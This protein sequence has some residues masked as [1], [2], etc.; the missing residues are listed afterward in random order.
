[1]DAHHP[2]D[3]RGVEAPVI[4]AFPAPRAPAPTRPAVGARKASR[5]MGNLPEEVAGFVGRRSEISRIRKLLAEARLVTLTGPGGVGKSRLALRVAR[6]V[7]RA[8]PKGV[9]FVELS[10]LRDPSSVAETVLATLEVRDQS[11]RPAVSVLAEYL[12]DKHLLLVVDNCEHLLDRCGALLSRLLAA[13]PGLSI[14]ATSRAPLGIA[15]EHLLQ[16][17]PLSAPG[18]GTS[19]SD[20]AFAPGDGRRFESLAL[21]EQRAAAVMPDFRLTRTNEV[22]VARICERLDGLPLAIELAA[23]R[24]SVLSPDEILTRLNNRYKLLTGGDRSGPQRHQTLQ[25]A[26]EWSFDLCSAREQRLWAQLS[27]FDRG[28]DMAAAEAVCAGTGNVF[29][30]IAELVDKSVIIR[31]PGTEPA[32]YRLLETIREFGRE[33]LLAHAGADTVRREHQRY[34]AGLAEQAEADWSGPGLVETAGR[35]QRERANLWAALDFSFAHLENERAGL[36]MVGALW[37]YW[38]GCGLLPEG[39]AWL[40]RA[41]AGDRSASLERAKALWVAGW[42]ALLQGELS[43]AADVL[44]ECRNLALRIGDNSALTYATQFRGAVVL[45]ADNPVEGICL[46][47]EAAAGHRLLG[48]QNAITIIGLVWLALAEYDAGNMARAESICAECQRICEP[49]C[50]GWAWSWTLWVRSMIAWS[51]DDG[52]SARADLREA[53]RIKRALNDTLGIATCLDTLARFAI[54]D[55][56]TERAARLLGSCQT[57]WQPIG[58]PLFAFQS[59]LRLQEK[60]EAR[61]KD[62]LGEEYFDQAH[63]AG[64][65][66]SMDDAIALALDEQQPDA[67]AAPAECGLAELTGRQRE[68]ARLIA[69][70]LSNREIA[71]AL[72]ISPRTAEAHVENILTKLGFSSR[73]QVAAWVGARQRR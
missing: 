40:M 49:A 42:I 33:R 9:W 7:R 26:V 62:E 30:G 20:S 12:A 4:T 35:L 57:L 51:T 19:N 72:V 48:E 37:P 23:A 71:T 54:D 56:D 21:F 68:V 25:A 10:G 5:V 29:Q 45:C 27:V 36:H 44:D 11:A 3:V 69:R 8:F 6:E 2:M 73:S 55:H 46:L 63:Q 67:Q 70:G 38:V 41:L 13:A 64:Q 34:Y 15:G 24:M 14:L 65:R 60:Y 58:L 47:E 17:P 1:M 53:L 32:R 59:L 66:L 31:E 43:A 52:P 50:E 61:A 39:R 22:V 16:V 28:F 18:A